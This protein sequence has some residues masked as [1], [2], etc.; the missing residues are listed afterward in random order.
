MAAQQGAPGL[1]PSWSRSAL[2]AAVAT[3]VALVVVLAVYTSGSRATGLDLWVDARAAPRLEP[4]RRIFGL[5]T[6]LAGPTEVLVMAVG[7]AAGCLALRLPGA[8]AV[9]VAGPVA[10]L[11][12]T[13]HLQSTL[14]RPAVEGAG[15]AFPSGHATAA[16]SLTTVVVVLLL[17][18]G[19]L[20][21]RLPLW[22]S[23]MLWMVAVGLPAYVAGALLLLRHHYVTD[24]LGGAGVAVAVVLLLAAVI[25]RLGAGAAADGRLVPGRGT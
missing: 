8:A 15:N 21:R 11:V 19:A 24:V 23:G 25:D 6:E 10:A 4:L 18:G 5:L 17:P 3:A 16:F 13:E 22:C 7:L 12:V 14:A 9:C 1:V 20:V 2:P